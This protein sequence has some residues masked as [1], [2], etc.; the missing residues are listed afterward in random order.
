MN[1]FLLFSSEPS[2]LSYFESGACWLRFFIDLCQGWFACKRLKDKDSSVLPEN[3]PA[4]EVWKEPN[5]PSVFQ[6]Q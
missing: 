5:V 3:G 4:E 2:P 6:E 1:I